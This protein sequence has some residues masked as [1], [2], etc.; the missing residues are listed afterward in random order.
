VHGLIPT[1]KR[2]ADILRAVEVDEA[3]VAAVAD[4]LGM[5]P[6]NAAVRLHRA[7]QALRKRLDASLRTCTTHGCLD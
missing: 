2:Y 4:G 3:P 1:L 7:R 5:S 6:G